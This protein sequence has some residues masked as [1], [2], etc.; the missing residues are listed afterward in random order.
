MAEVGDREYLCCTDYGKL[1]PCLRDCSA[2]FFRDD[3]AL[4]T[5]AFIEKV[6]VF[7]MCELEKYV[8]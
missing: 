4:W 3:P 8:N 1:F 5:C 7:E 2:G 6:F